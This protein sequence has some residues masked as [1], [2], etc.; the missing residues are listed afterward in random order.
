MK[1][2]LITV[3][4]GM[5]AA[6]SCPAAPAVSADLIL[7]GGRVRTPSGWAEAVA[8]RGET[9]LATGSAEEVGA[10]RARRTIVLDLGGDTVLPGLHDTHVHPLFAGLRARQCEI[11]QGSSLARL[12]AA[13]EGCVSRA[14]PQT[15]IVGGQWDASS[16]GRVPDRG[17]IDAITGDHPALLS[18]TSGHS[19]LANS[20]ALAAAGITRDTPNPPGGIVERDALGEPTG[21]LR[22]SAIELVAK[23]VP[24]PADT[25]TQEALAWALDTMLSFGITSFTEADMG[26]IAGPE[27]EIR[28]YAAL[29][30]SGRLKQ[31]ARLCLQWSP[32]NAADEAVIMSRNFYARDR[33][34]PVCVKAILDGVPTD[35][36]T[37][38]MVEPYGSEMEGRSDDAARY[39]LLLVEPAVLNEA[40]TRFDRMGLAMKFHAAGDAA[41]RAGLNAIEA[42]RKS[43]GFSGLLH[44]VAHCT[45]VHEDDVGRARALGA[46]FEVSPYLW[47]PTPINDDITRAIGDARMKR[48][49]PVRDLLESGALVVP[50]SDWSVVPSVSPW[51]G[52]ETLVT[53]EKPGGS[54]KS[55]G[56]GQAITLE[57]AFDMFTVNAARYTGTA[58]RVG[59]IEPGMLADIIVVDRNPFEIPITDVHATR[60]KGTY[61]GGERV[62]DASR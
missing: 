11:E 22:E 8:I 14:A 35:S 32:G 12:Q 17:M 28:A 25:E 44:D 55:F 26:F 51:I 58:H 15:W 41:V 49:W 60:V 62:Y 33:V 19:S 4:A 24:P 45:F 1:R 39:G 5:L 43:N 23:L 2:T 7:T 36:H 37:A 18:D 57:Q 56:K 50:G 27:R 13:L 42:A 38:A 3:V 31:R 52:M 30:D 6:G 54:A 53:R 46:V 61:I 10:Y 20:H 59:R 16:L 9:I 34:A 29:A 21:V 47:T 40:V 48:V